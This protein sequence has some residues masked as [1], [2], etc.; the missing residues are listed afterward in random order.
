MLD[1]DNI[2]VGYG[3]ITCLRNVSLNVRSGEI[4]TLI[5]ANGAGKSTTLRTISG[6]LAPRSG[7]ITFEGTDIGGLNPDRIVAL[8]A[9]LGAAQAVL[10]YALGW[11]ATD[12]RFWAG[13]HERAQA[14]HA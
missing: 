12:A 11:R 3:D 2:V 13:A 9:S 8:P 14:P 1:L 7:R 5:G 6:L 4:V 10:R